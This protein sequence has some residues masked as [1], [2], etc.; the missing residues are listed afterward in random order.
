MIEHTCIPCL[1]SAASSMSAGS[2]STDFELVKPLFHLIRVPWLTLCCFMGK[3]KQ[4][5]TIGSCPDCGL[6]YSRQLIILC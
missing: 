2:S 1:A 4:K 6:Q 3:L 5:P